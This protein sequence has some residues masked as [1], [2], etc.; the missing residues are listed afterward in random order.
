VPCKIIYLVVQRRVASYTRN[1][2]Q[3]ISS[4]HN[5]PSKF[6]ISNTQQFASL[7]E[8]SSGTQEGSE[9]RYRSWNKARQSA[10][11]TLIHLPDEELQTVVKLLSASSVCTCPLPLISAKQTSLPP[12]SKLT[13]ACDDTGSTVHLQYQTAWL[14]IVC[15]GN[16]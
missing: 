15:L 3:S 4:N 5:L 7:K 9:Y 14:D 13:S 10:R 11:S 1:W 8:L 6:V 2:R 12:G 16:K